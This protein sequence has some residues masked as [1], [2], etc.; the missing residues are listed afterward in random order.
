ML[1]LISKPIL[2]FALMVFASACSKKG[3]G[4][5]PSNPPPNDGSRNTGSQI[6]PG[7]GNPNTPG[8]NPNSGP[9]GGSNNGKSNP[10]TQLGRSAPPAP[11]SQLPPDSRYNTGEGKVVLVEDKTISPKDVKVSMSEPAAASVVSNSYGNYLQ[12]PPGFP[13]PVAASPIITGGETE[14]EYKYVDA[15]NDSLMKYLVNLADD[16]TD[17]NKEFG[18]NSLRLA[19]A[20]SYIDSKI[21]RDNGKFRI[22][23]EIKSNER[24][25]RIPFD[26]RLTANR[27]AV[28]YNNEELTTYEE[29]DRKRIPGHRS[30]RFKLTMVCVDKTTGCE[31]A[32]M[33]MDQ[34]LLKD[35]VDRQKATDSDW[36]TCRSIYAVARFGNIHLQIDEHDYKFHTSYTNINQRDFVRMLA[37]SAHY[38]RYLSKA[39]VKLDHP[40]PLRPRL[41]KST[42]ESW[43]VAYGSAGFQINLISARALNGQGLTEGN[44]SSFRGPMLW[45]PDRIANDNDMYPFGDYVDQS[46]GAMVYADMVETAK[47]VENDGRGQIAIVLNF[48]DAPEA[49]TQVN[50][51]TLFAETIDP[52]GQRGQFISLPELP[53]KENQP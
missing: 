16:Q 20:I 4:G 12:N 2:M 27:R 23:F 5:E 29:I 10:D 43:A 49:S 38:V 50:F 51:T 11:G 41:A 30:R 1:K 3:G 47:L 31:S 35:G 53:V 32:I 6:P 18:E 36:E 24:T 17:K 26:N 19:R 8:G 33:R 45:A 52:T 25:Y 37:N 14:R 22:V 15:Y 9:N 42:I 39:L 46:R 48:H 44:V 21:Q 34:L 40:Y 7:R 28:V 13:Y